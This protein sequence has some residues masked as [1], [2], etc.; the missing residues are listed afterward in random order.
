MEWKMGR[1]T[2]ELLDHESE[3]VYI[4]AEQVINLHVPKL[5]DWGRSESINV[6]SPVVHLLDGKFRFHIEM[7]SGDLIEVTAGKIE[8]P[9]QRT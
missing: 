9:K 2:F 5:D 4:I 1:V 6:I 3:R 8:L 7:Q